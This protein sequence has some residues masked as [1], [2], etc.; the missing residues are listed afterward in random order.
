MQQAATI[1]IVGK[2]NVGKSTLFN[3]LIGKRYAITSEIAGTTRDRISHWWDC[4]G[5]DTLLVDTGGLEDEAKD[6][7][8]AD[9]QSQARLAIESADLIIFIIDINKELTTDDFTAAG[10]LRKSQKSVLFVANKCDNPKSKENIYNSYELGFGEPICISSIHNSGISDLEESVEKSLK[11]LKFTK[12]LSTLKKAK[13]E[14]NI[15]ILGKPNVGKSS[16][17]NAL[18][19]KRKHIVS[20]IP[21]TTRDTIDSEIEYNGQKYNLIDTAGIRRRGKIEKGIEKF[22]SF[23]SLNAVE[24]S[25]III[26][27]MDGAEHISKQDCH[28]AEWAL[29]KEKGLILLINKIDLFENY[30]ENEHYVIRQ[31]RFKFD[32]VPWAPVL[33]VS[34]KTKKNIFEIFNLVD[35]IVKERHKRIPTPQLNAFLQKTTYKHI[36]SSRNLRKP[37][38]FYASQVEVD[39]P[40]FVFFFRNAKN[41][42]FSY[43]RYLEN[44]IRKEFGFEGTSLRLKFKSS[45]SNNGKEASK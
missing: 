40:T 35:K 34:A 37:K 36:P 8:E 22:S 31:L 20:D 44:E 9:V 26:L 2:P 5:Y 30:T 19:G 7:I 38:F 45:L 41:L 1:A 23:R 43:P 16:L 25:D 18:L 21:G 27:M 14:T 12:S 11:A 15:C 6:N 3:R 4:R 33:F 29:E 28:I 24:R 17:I 10:I 39:P 42:H 13:N 32:F